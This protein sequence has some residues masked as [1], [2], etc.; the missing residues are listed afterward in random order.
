LQ[1][2]AR[3]SGGG[4]FRGAT[5]TNARA[6]H[7]PIASDALPAGTL[8]DLARADCPEN[9]RNIIGRPAVRRFRSVYAS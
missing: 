9:L 1:Q 6:E 8:M 5:V 7:H 4:F 2:A 3:L